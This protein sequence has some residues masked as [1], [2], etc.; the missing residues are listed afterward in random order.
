MIGLRE[1][2][3]GHEWGHRSD[4]VRGGKKID[5]MAVLNNQLHVEVRG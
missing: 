1:S 3:R 5:E 4:T 2:N